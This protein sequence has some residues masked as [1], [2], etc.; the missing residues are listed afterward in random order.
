MA[1]NESIQMFDGGE[2]AT[3]V[4]YDKLDNEYRC[5]KY[6]VFILEGGSR[7][8]KTISIIQ[9]WLQWAQ[10][11]EGNE[12]KVIVSRA[13]GT[14]IEGTVLADFLKVLKAYGWYDEKNHNKTK[15]IYRLFDTEFWFVGLDDAQKIHGMTSDAFWINEAIEATKND[16]DQVEMRCAGFGIID[17][18]PSEE[19]HW[20]YDSVCKRADACFI[21]S[22]MLDNAFLPENMRRKILSYDPSNPANVAAGTANKKMW[23]IYGLGL[24]AKIEGLVFDKIELVDYIPTWIKN[25]VTGLDFGYTNDPTAGGEVAWQ[26]NDLYIHEEFY[27]T[28]MLTS[29]IIKKLKDVNN[30]RDIISE[31]ADPRLIDEIHNAGFNIY[32][33][34]KGKGS[35]DAGLSKMK[36]MRIFVTRNSYNA[37]KEFKNYTYKQ[38]KNG[39]WL[40]E[41]IDAWNHI[42]DFV[43]Y[44]VLMRILGKKTEKKKTGWVS[45]LP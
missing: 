34:E 20:I 36:S 37:I 8:S 25:R 35:V 7:S 3:T 45:A 29:D 24:R 14:W 43:R 30:G 41:P 13:V 42:I 19:E 5:G 10:D 21:H 11:N 39:K 28:M 9:F 31:N 22:T 23:E 4:V 15:K 32:P 40:N 12:K 18:N 6:N 26:G 27:Q 33:V 17:Y 2:V 44:V 38:D 1:E 16:F